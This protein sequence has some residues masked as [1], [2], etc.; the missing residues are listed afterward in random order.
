MTDERRLYL[1][2]KRAR[3]LFNTPVLGGFESWLFTMSKIKQLKIK[4]DI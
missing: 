3:F 1:L 4:M 2:C